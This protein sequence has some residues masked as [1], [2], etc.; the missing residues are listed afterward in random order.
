MR[1]GIAFAAL[2]FACRLVSACGPVTPQGAAVAE[3]AMAAACPELALIPVVGS[4]LAQVCI[5]EEAALKAALDAAIAKQAAA[6]DGG[7]AGVALPVGSTLVPVFARRGAAWRHIGNVPKPLARDV[8]AIL[9]G[10]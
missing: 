10:G 8:Q 3:A 7:K 1:S 2:L 6:A 5:G 9:T 4:I